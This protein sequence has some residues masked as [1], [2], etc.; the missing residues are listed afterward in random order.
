V[1]ISDRYPT[2]DSRLKVF[3]KGDY[4]CSKLKCCPWIST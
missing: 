1:K 4:G 2:D 3:D